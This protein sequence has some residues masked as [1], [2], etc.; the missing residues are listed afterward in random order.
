[1][2]F[3]VL[4]LKGKIFK[5]KPTWSVSELG[6]TFPKNLVAQFTSVTFTK[7]EPWT[8]ETEVRRQGTGARSSCNTRGFKVAAPQK[9]L[10]SLYVKENAAKNFEVLQL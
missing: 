10:P 7:Y 5:K 3:I 9:F 8:F 4:L 1:M 6:N 2:K